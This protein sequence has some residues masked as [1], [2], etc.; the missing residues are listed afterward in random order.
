MPTLSTYKISTKGKNLHLRVVKGHFA[1][2]NSHM[3]YYVDVTVQ[4]SRLSE[5]TAVANAI[6]PYYDHS[7]VID[8]ILCLDGM[9]VIGTCI[10]EKLTREDFSN[11]NAHQTIYIVTPE[12]TSGSQIIFRDSVEP[13]IKGKISHCYINDAIIDDSKNKD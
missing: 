7:T 1:T 3:N 5:A 2:S 9:Q 12:Q 6:V 13:M 10:A 4:K 11:M 8:T